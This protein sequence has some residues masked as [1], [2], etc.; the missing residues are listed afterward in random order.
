MFWFG[1]VIHI[2]VPVVLSPKTPLQIVNSSL[3]CLGVEIFPTG[4]RLRSCD[5]INS[6]FTGIPGAI[7]SSTA[8]IC[9]PWLSPKSVT[10]TLVPNEFFIPN[11]IPS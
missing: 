11:L 8:P 1:I 6:L 2:G 4:A 9:A 3:S 7:P 5:E 10:E